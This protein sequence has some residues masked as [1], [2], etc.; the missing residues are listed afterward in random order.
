MYK[1]IIKNI[2]DLSFGIF[3]II[4]LS[5]FFLIVCA[6]LKIEHKT[7]GLFYTQLRP[8]KNEKIFKIIK[9]KTMSDL[10]DINGKL[11]PD[12]ERVTKVGKILRSFSIDEL[13]QFINIIKGDMSLIGPRPLR[14]DYL[15]LYSERHKK[16]HFVKPG[17]TGWA[18]VNGRNN[19]SWHQKF[20]YDIWYVE[21]CSLLLDL[22]IIILTIKK[23][24][25]KE[26]VSKEGHLTTEPFNGYN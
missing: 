2:I 5:P 6:L 1:F 13:P 24:L 18:Q 26:G 7:N 15:K 14:V 11:L 23:V 8:G 3:V 19:I 25:I 20:E 9:F 22:K 4:V 16:R 12:N 10:K 17:L 21:N